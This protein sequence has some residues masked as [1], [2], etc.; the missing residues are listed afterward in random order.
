MTA[1][2]AAVIGILLLLTVIQ[3]RKALIIILTITSP[4]AVLLYILPGTKKTFN[5]WFSLFKGLLFA[6]PICSLLV[7]GGAFAS[8]ILTAA[9]GVANEDGSPNFFTMVI[10]VAASI[11]PI[12]LIP[13]TIIKSAGALGA[14][15]QGLANK[16]K[17]A[18]T[19]GMY[20]TRI[21]QRLDRGAKERSNRMKAGV[22][23]NGNETRLGRL[24]R[25]RSERVRMD[26][27]KRA[28]NDRAIKR[29]EDNAEEMAEYEEMEQVAN[30]KEEELASVGAGQMPGTIQN[31]LEGDGDARTIA[32]ELSGAIKHWD[33]IEA[34]P[35]GDNAD[36]V[37]ARYLDRLSEGSDD[38][39]A[40]ARELGR[41]IARKRLADSEGVLKAKN[42]GMH[43]YYREM[44]AVDPS[45]TDPIP[46]WNG[47]QIDTNSKGNPIIEHNHWV[48][49]LVQSDNFNATWLAGVA[50]PQIEQ[51][52]SYMKSGAD[53]NVKRQIAAT[54]AEMK[55]TGAYQSATAD[56]YTGLEAQI[57]KY[58][59]GP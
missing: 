33:S 39:K 22:D 44:A 35:K 11:V 31:I 48:E 5:Q 28:A 10:A 19:Q 15:L 57:N 23:R 8:T 53:D 12:F 51:L 20:N 42:G 52:E 24:T 3:L 13:N 43:Q 40:R 27:A 37:I 9:M 30:A 26:A 56:D 36:D 21:G 6:Y 55:R 49:Q 50:P 7:K 59:A 16:L 18:L 58:N 17:G 45:S 47:A 29:S 2:L 32:A 38:D 46:K 25:S 34:K 41:E 14:R 1:A 54:Y 4:V